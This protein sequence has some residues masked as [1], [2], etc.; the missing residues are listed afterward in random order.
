[1]VSF[2]EEKAGGDGGGGSGG[3]GGSGDGGGGKGGDGDGGSQG[4]VI[5]LLLQFAGVSPMGSRPKAQHDGDIVADEHS[6]A[7]LS[8]C[9]AEKNGGGSGGDLQR[10][11][12][13]QTEI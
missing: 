6:I 5:W 12:V 2:G 9:G 13:K 3:E 10:S 11:G 4:T 8:F 7:P 1:M